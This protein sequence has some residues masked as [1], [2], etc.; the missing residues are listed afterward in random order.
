LTLNEA[1][2]HP[3]VNG[4]K[5]SEKQI[6]PDVIRV[7][8][9]FNKQ[10][11]LKKAITKVLALNM[12]NEPKRKIRVHFNRLDKNND[13]SLDI[14]ELSLLLADMGLAENVAKEDARNIMAETDAD[15][16]GTI[17]F[18]EFAQIWQ[19]KLLSVNESYIHA[20]FGV[21]DEDG[22][23]TIEAEELARVLKMEGKENEVEIKSYISEV[24]TDNDG[25]INF[26][27]FKAAMLEK[28][29]FNGSNA[30]VGFQLEEKE[31]TGNRDIGNV[32]IDASTN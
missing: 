3:W 8:R 12:G 26:K 29:E 19:R 9:Q 31:I 7:L 1:L 20:V 32:D 27:E 22:N 2:A 11:K 16:S 24:D 18:E 13:G 15:G 21:L 10:S 28:G 17:E 30:G 25:K 4:E 6:S 14:N 5:A 23:G